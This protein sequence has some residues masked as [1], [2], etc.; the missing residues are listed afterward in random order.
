MIHLAILLLSF[1]FHY[2]SPR[3]TIEE[4]EF[5]ELE[6]L[7]YITEEL[8]LR[9]SWSDINTSLDKDKSGSANKADIY[10][11]TVQQLVQ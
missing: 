8:N 4:T 9:D 2:C 3:L 5:P 6:V 1:L 7:P 11:E 10:L